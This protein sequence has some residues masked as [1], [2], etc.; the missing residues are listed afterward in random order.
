MFTTI[1]AAIA[2]V[3]ALFSTKPNKKWFAYIAALIMLVVSGWQGYSIYKKDIDSQA[4]KKHEYSELHT[5][6]N[7]ILSIISRML[8]ESSS[9]K[10]PKKEEDIFSVQVAY[11]LCWHLNVESYALVIPDRIWLL[12]ISQE[13]EEV[14]SRL[15][16]IISNY[17]SVLPASTID[18]VS[19]VLSSFLFNFPQQ[20]N[21]V[22]K[23]DKQKGH[24]RPPILCP[25]LENL[26]YESLIEIKELYDEMRFFEDSTT[27]SP[28]NE[29]N[30]YE[31]IIGKSRF[32]KNDLKHWKAKH[33]YAPSGHP[34]KKD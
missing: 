26:M 27:I 10:L 13:I 23:Y 34:T 20:F 7:K 4:L 11:D 32:T 25:G 21:E 3:L 9:G 14:S 22:R 6:T 28:I 24:Q 18:S 16:S 17:G 19:K 30:K 2:S 5:E 31:N 1:L 33:R 12:W 15:N 8:V 29:I